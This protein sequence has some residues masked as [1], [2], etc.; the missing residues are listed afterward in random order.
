MLFDYSNLKLVRGSAN[1][2]PLED[3]VRGANGTANVIRINN[4][5]DQVERDM[6]RLV[7]QGKGNLIIG[8]GTEPMEL[9]A[10]PNNYCLT[11]DP[12]TPSGLVWEE[13][14][15]VTANQR[16]GGKKTFT[17][18]LETLQNLQVG[19]DMGVGGNATVVGNLSVRNGHLTGTLEVGSSTL[20]HN[21]LTVA[22]NTTLRTNLTV[23][24]ATALTTAVVSSTL[25]VGGDVGIDS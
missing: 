2:Q 12:T 15:D 18:D 13:R 10:G 11:V 7:P 22:N 21:T 6:G 24:G 8:G 20:L 3:P 17:S 16:V 25:S 5:I 4:F 1:T 14:V 23:G 19:L 9:Q